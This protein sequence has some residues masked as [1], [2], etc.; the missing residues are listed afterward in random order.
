MRGASI[1]RLVVLAGCLTVPLTGAAVRRL[2]VFPFDVS[3]TEG[4]L[5]GNAGISLEEMLRDTAVVA[6]ANDGW[7]VL[8]SDATAMALKKDGLDGSRC[9]DEACHMT[10][11]RTLHADYFLTGTAQF[12]DNDLVCSIRLYDVA[13]DRIL[14][15]ERV[16]GTTAKELRQVFE[17]RAPE[18]FR[19]VRL[20]TSGEEEG[21]A[22]A[23]DPTPAPSA[24]EQTPPQAPVVDDAPQMDLHFSA[25]SVSTLKIVG[26]PE[27]ASVAITDAEGV[28]RD[29]VIPWQAKNL[30][31]ERYKIRITQPGFTEA[32]ATVDLEPGK[33]TQVTVNLRKIVTPAPEPI[34]SLPAPLASGSTGACVND[35]DCPGENVCESK[36]CVAPT[37]KK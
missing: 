4:R 22:A 36:L 8:S 2:G 18:F 6:L 34:V 26:S 20:V 13:A 21:V 28:E 32:R 23:K 31:S 7:T 19:R 16:T 24:P 27:G 9:T 11:A 1:A 35:I 14:T 25:E 10:L 15:S 30:P 29:G 17:A 33:K 3:H 12:V 37:L 5:T